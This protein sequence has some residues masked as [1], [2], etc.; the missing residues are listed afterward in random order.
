LE[1]VSQIAALVEVSLFVKGQQIQQGGAIRF[2]PRSK[3]VAAM[4]CL[5][6]FISF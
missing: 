3:T 4:A 5:K 1:R 6:A 2:W